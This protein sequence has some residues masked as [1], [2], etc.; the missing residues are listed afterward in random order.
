MR[1]VI[2]C[3]ICGAELREL[4]LV[5]YRPRFEPNADRGRSGLH[6]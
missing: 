2:L 1:Y 4:G 6:A 5:D 3:D